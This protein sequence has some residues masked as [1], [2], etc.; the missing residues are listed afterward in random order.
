MRNRIRLLGTFLLAVVVASSIVLA[1]SC[2]SE[3]NV[4]PNAIFDVDQKDSTVDEEFHIS[5]FRSYI[6]QLQFF[7]D[8]EADRSRV[9]RLI[10]DGSARNRGMVLPIH[11]QIFYESDGS[12][13]ERLLYDKNI[14]T[15]GS[16]GYRDIDIRRNNGY[17]VREL[18]SVNLHPGTYRF[19]TRTMMDNAA[20]K[21]TLVRLMI[22]VR[23][24]L[25]FFKNAV[26]LSGM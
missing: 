14:D 6:F 10:G 7:F 5:E 9:F 13:G 22:G 4:L 3:T 25:K 2:L 20:F 1:K 16:I 19:V 24:G 15:S 23:P 21:G 12:R 11:I 17:V 8:N 26:D 18:V